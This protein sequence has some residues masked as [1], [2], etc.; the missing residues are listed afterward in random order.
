MR[1]RSARGGGGHHPL[2]TATLPGGWS[3]VN[4]HPILVLEVAGE[5]GASADWDIYFGP[6]AAAILRNRGLA[7]DTFRFGETLIVEGHPARVAGARAVDV[8]GN[9]AGITRPGGTRVP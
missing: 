3:F 9:A 7:P 8:F 6:A 1:R 4:P 5:N 2:R